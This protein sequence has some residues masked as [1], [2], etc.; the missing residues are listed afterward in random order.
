MSFHDILKGFVLLSEQLKVQ[1][2]P[3]KRKVTR[4]KPFP[5]EL[6]KNITKHFDSITKILIIFEKRSINISTHVFY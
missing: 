4:E 1:K 3:T 6:N 5:V 2:E